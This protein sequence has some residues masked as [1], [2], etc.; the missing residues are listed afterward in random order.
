M[1][2]T[3]TRYPEP[4][5]AE[6]QA[7]CSITVWDCDADPDEHSGEIYR[8]NGYAERGSVHSLLKYAEENGERL[9]R[10][11]LAWIHDLGERRINGKRL[12][13]H[14]AIE[15]GLSYWWMTL[16]FEKSFYKSPITDAIRLLA[17][18]E[19]VVRIKPGRLRLL[20]ANRDLHRVLCRYCRDHGVSYKWTRTPEQARRHSRLRAIYRALPQS[21]Q[22]MLGLLR[23]LRARWAL[24][25]PRVS[26]WSGGERSLFFCS[27]FIHLDSE[28]CAAGEF[29]SH[30]WENLPRVLHE[31]GYRT[32]WI[33]HYLESSAV[34]GTRVAKQ[35]ISNFNTLHGEREFHAFLD[36]ELSWRIV[37]RALRRWFGL[38][39]LSWRL[40]GIKDGFA[41]PGTRI[42]LWPVMRRDWSASM[43]GLVAIQNMLAVELFD[44][45]LRNIPHQKKG[46]YLCENQAWERALIHAWR[47]HGHGELIGAV[48]AT[49]RFW[50]LRYFIDARTARLSG[51]YLVP[52]PDLVALNGRAAVDAYLAMDFPRERIAEC[53]AL[54]YDYLR[55]V[56][57]PRRPRRRKGDPLSVLILGDYLPSAT[58]KMLR[59][60]EAAVPL[61]SDRITCSVKPHPSCPIEA[62]HYPS[63]NLRI[64]LDS[65]GTLLH[66]FDI[67]YSSSITSS[68]LDAHLAGLPV[69]IMRDETELDFSPLRGRSG[70]RFVTTPAELT[71]AL[72]N[73][74]LEGARKPDRD[75]WFFL[76][77]G[78]PRWQKLLL[79]TKAA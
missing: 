49:V 28:S 31:K 58:A 71:E 12:I 5:P 32:N 59:L 48:H 54:R 50:D 65:L 53:E 24:R 16:L 35:W 73:A 23:H 57:V 18:D 44:K 61:T 60:I 64:I 45:A 70:V 3:K 20:S 66:R 15:E 26:G 74:G 47:K 62:E 37:V 33:Q 11:Y 67:A 25:E 76:N 10:K 6:V 52:Q 13:D 77:P 36:A 14:L 41:P 38:N 17:L 55:D 1:D 42:S 8:W 63:L 9:R 39:L 79:S 75:E 34:P 68:A 7:G 69:V 29:H 21:M 27:Y 4:E 2:S 46:L 22:A 72:Q 30:H 19:V 40:K 56:G 43:R 78:L 51:P